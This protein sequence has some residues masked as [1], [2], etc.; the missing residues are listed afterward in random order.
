MLLCWACLPVSGSASPSLVTPERT[1]ERNTTCQWCFKKLRDFFFPH[2]TLA[3]ALELPTHQG[4]CEKVSTGLAEMMGAKRAPALWAVGCWCNTS[5][6]TRDLHQI[7]KNQQALASEQSQKNSWTNYLSCLSPQTSK[8][9]W[10][11]Q[12]TSDTKYLF[13]S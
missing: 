13:F 6:A 4:R 8:L 10:G 1:T 9:R 7:W 5:A 11:K 2:M 12:K 3:S